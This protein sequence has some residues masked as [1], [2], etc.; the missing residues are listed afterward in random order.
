MKKLMMILWKK[1][2]GGIDLKLPD[3]VN[4][5]S[6]GIPIF[7]GVENKKVKANKKNVPTVNI[8]Y[9]CIFG[10]TDIL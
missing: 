7:G 1:I 5:K 8:N 2:F 9:V 3:N 10:G 4:V 6:S